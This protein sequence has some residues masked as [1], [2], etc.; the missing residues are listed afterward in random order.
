MGVMLPPPFSLR[1]LIPHPLQDSCFRSSL[2]PA[3]EVPSS[4]P[5]ALDF[6]CISLRLCIVGIP[7]PSFTVGAELSKPF[8]KYLSVSVTCVLSGNTSVCNFTASSSFHIEKCIGHSHTSRSSQVFGLVLPISTSLVFIPL[9]SYSYIHSL[10][11]HLTAPFGL[12]LSCPTPAWLAHF[13]CPSP[14]SPSSVT[15]QKHAS[16]MPV[17]LALTNAVLAHPPGSPSQCLFHPLFHPAIRHRFVPQYSSGVQVH[18]LT[19]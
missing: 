19:S 10:S 5:L 6:L 17:L 3:Y 9:L 16:V 14:C 4:P 8:L 15:I 12:A 2:T 13:C 1:G 7:F 11:W 18:T